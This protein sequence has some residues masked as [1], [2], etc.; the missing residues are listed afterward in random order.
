MSSNV[1]NNNGI[2]CKY[3]IP[4][5]LISVVILLVGIAL[6]IDFSTNVIIT[7]TMV[8]ST[9]IV[10]ISLLYFS[11]LLLDN[12]HLHIKNFKNNY[13]YIYI[14]LII[15]FIIN[16]GSLIYFIQIFSSNTIIHKINNNDVL[17]NLK[18][19]VSHFL[20]VLFIYILIIYY[21]YSVIN[22]NPNDIILGLLIFF[23]FSEAIIEFLLLLRIMNTLK[24]ITDG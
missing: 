15:T 2:M 13:T 20:S 24:H 23:A 10:L 16:L 21:I 8:S 22:C 17:S 4:F 1:I 7:N 18:G 6:I 3:T 19:D 11:Y 14:S 5:L 9:I 12:L